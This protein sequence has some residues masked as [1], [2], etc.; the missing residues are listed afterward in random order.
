MSLSPA[1]PP[2]SITNPPPPPS[3]GGGG[4]KIAI[5]FGAVI[6]LLAGVIYLFYQVNNLQKQV[7]QTN[8]AVMSKIA[9]LREA[10]SITTQTNRRSIDELKDQLAAAQKQESTLVGQARIDAQKHAEDL[11]GQIKAEQQ[12]QI[13]QVNSAVNQVQEAANTANTKIG[14]VSTEVGSVKTDLGTTKSELEKTIAQL[15]TTVGDLG[16]QSGLIATNGKEIS[17]LR[18]LGERNIFEFKIG[19]TKAPQKVGDIAIQLKK[20]DPKKNRYTMDV[21]VDDKRVEKKDRTINEPVQFYTSKAR[22]PY[23]IVV[24]SVDKN[25]IAGYLSTPKVQ[26]AR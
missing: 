17:A 11:A 1:T 14:E 22:Q 9:E 7:A 5:L 12:R 18:A 15:K 20:T 24:N 26:D 16:V 2:S 8:D 25:L 10:S 21:I 4:A 19:K 23:E 6:A 13:A 3:S